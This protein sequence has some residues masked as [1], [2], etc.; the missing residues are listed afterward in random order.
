MVEATASST[1][2]EFNVRQDRGKPHFIRLHD[3]VVKNLEWEMAG[4][5]EQSGVLL[6]A[7]ESGENCTIV[8]EEFERAAK[9]EERIQTRRPGSGLNAMQEHIDAFAGRWDGYCSGEELLRRTR[10]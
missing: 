8:V 7:I 9:L 10:P 3:S 1:F 2:T 4:A 6:G 5:G